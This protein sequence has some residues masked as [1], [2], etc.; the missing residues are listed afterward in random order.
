[1]WII[2]MKKRTSVLWRYDKNDDKDEK[3][4]QKC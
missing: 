2:L 1:M 3:M 4:N